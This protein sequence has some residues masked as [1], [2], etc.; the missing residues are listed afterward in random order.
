MILASAWA[1]GRNTRVV[2]SSVEH[3]PDRV[4]VLEHIRAQVAVGEGAALRPTRRT[5]R[6]DDRGEAIGREARDALVEDGVVYVAAAYVSLESAGVD[7]EDSRHA[8]VSAGPVV[9]LPSSASRR[10]ASD[11]ALSLD[12]PLELVG[13]RRLVHGHG[14]TAGREDRVV[15]DEPL[16]PSVRHEHDPGAR[17]DAARDEPLASARTRP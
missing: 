17:L 4:D 14:H 3:R 12:D 16:E 8:V 13:R 5:G 15:D 10:M 2:S 1:S 6:V 7:H 9:L 11:R